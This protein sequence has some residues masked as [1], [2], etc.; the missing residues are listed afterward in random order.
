MV[1]VNSMSDLFHARVPTEFI[2][3]VFSV[4]EATSQHTY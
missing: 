1:F 2:Q 3:D 4:M